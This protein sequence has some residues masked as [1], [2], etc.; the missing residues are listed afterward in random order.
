MQG[1]PAAVG[2]AMVTSLQRSLPAMCEEVFQ[3]SVLPSFERSCQEMFRQIDE[4]FRRGTMGC[5]VVII[6]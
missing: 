5:K 6:N 1:L 4:S 2:A 3:T